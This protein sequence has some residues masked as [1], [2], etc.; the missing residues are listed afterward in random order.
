VKVKTRDISFL[1]G[2]PVA[3]KLKPALVF[4]IM[5]YLNSMRY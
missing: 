1:K 4:D 5:N 2:I 3:D